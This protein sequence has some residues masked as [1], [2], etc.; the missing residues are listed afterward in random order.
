LIRIDLKGTNK[1][2]N[3]M[4]TD[5][6]VIHLEDYKPT[7][8]AIEHVEMT[9][10]LSA[11][12]TQ[13]T[14]SLHIT[15][16]K[17]IAAGTALELDGE[18]LTLL[19]AKLNG[20]NL[21]S[22]SYSVSANKFRLHTPPEGDFVLELE[23]ELDPSSNTQLMGLYRSS[24]TYCTQCEAE[25]FRR[26][27]YFY[28][29]PDVLATYKVRLEA[30]KKECPHILANGNLIESGLL[31]SDSAEDGSERH[32][33]IWED[34]FPKPSYLFACVAGDLARIED[35]FVTQSGRNV[36]LHI[37]VEHGKEDRVAYAM[38]ALKR[39]MKWDED[40]FG[41][42]YDL[43]IF[44]IVAVSD[45]NMGAM[46]NKGLNIFN[47]KYVLAKPDTATD[48]DYALIEAIIAHE[49]FHNWTG[50]RITCRD[51]FQLCLKEGLT[52]FRDQEFSSDMR[53]R[54]VKRI[55]DVRQLRA[56]QFPEDGGPLAHPVRP[57]SYSEINNFY[58]ATVY[59]KG[60]ELCRMIKAIVGADDFRKG[61]DLYFE[62]HDGDAST[63]EDFLAVF[64]QASGQDLSQFA[65]WYSQAGTPSVVVTSNYHAARK[66]LS[67]SVE[68]S[69]PATPGQPTK[70]VMHIPV[71]FGLV[72][73]NGQPVSFSGTSGGRV[74]MLETGGMLHITERKQT[75]TLKGV[76]APAIPSLLR[77]FS[78]PIYL[79]S[80][81]S[82]KDILQLLRHDEDSFN[83]WEAAQYLLMRALLS[84]TQAVE[85][86]M[87]YEP[88]SELIETLGEIVGDDDLEMAFRAEILNMP[89]EA[90]IAREIGRNVNPD[91]IHTALETFR[92]NVANAL[93]PSLHKLYTNLIDD[94][95]YSPDA[96]S[97]GKRALRNQILSLL[98][99]C[100][101]EGGEELAVQQYHEASNM[102][103]RFAALAS[104]TH[105]EKPSADALLSAFHDR[106]ADDA[107]VIDKWLSLQASSPKDGTLERVKSLLEHP[108][109]S[110]NNP[111]RA[112]SLIGAF[113]MNNARQF[114]RP[115]GKGYELVT[116]IIL[117]LDRT[118][119]QT[120]AR[121][122][123]NFRSWRVLEPTRQALAKAQLERIAETNPLSKDVADIANRCLQ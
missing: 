27:T 54:P 13:I 118:N 24:G 77:G 55:E 7:P 93:S 69:C 75:F 88:D 63:I 68:Q 121:L 76:R 78:A 62:R 15:P 8:Y 64:E 102:T 65:L 41:R 23:T 85:A 92:T 42:E 70:K 94:D 96:S 48:T 122:L 50:N 53:S 89:S 51:W 49:Y 113:A 31:P 72:G 25:G 14:S 57:T 123:N 18:D 20:A 119:P 79:R 61:M 81:L 17:G 1:K 106:Y 112:R 110:L 87:S 37:Y 16:R 109:F 45:F 83:R 82:D 39:S 71:Q 52:V 56:R 111:N 84:A 3:D 98:I 38:D 104:L 36:A 99:M 67:L 4:K 12:R 100:E 35:N 5:C 9:F 58:T 40:V 116:D 47:D 43:D 2:K 44:Q 90:D 59:E 107:L 120:A 95:A 86:G 97:A 60:A 29:R 80:N 73:T 108:S 22:D 19:S 34:P 101:G 66:E 10:L 33:A 74:D 11:N 114:N 26:I 103:D 115:D 6:A 28:D 32:Y 117:K 91:A 21:A 105:H 30:D 46:E